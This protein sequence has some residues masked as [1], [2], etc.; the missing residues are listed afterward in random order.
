MHFK[1]LAATGLLIN[2][3][4]IDV[5]INPANSNP[6]TVTQ[7]LLDL[8]SHKY[9]YVVESYF[10]NIPVSQRFGITVWNVTDA[11]S[12]IVSGGKQ[13]APTLFDNNYNKKPAF[14]GFAQGLFLA[15]GRWG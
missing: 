8:Q 15:S 13:D 7:A 5:R 3:S 12:W 9:Q 6:F 10:R 11:D 1:K 2:V 14:T 4:E